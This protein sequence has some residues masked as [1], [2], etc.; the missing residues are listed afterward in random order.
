MAFHLIN[1][2]ALCSDSHH[3]F[4]AGLQQKRRGFGAAP[5]LAE[6]AQFQAIG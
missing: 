6:Q 2:D 1:K 5:F 3:V 4:Q